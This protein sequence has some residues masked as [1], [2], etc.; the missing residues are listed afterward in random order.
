[1]YPNECLVAMWIQT[2]ISP[3]LVA[4]IMI[5]DAVYSLTI[6][7]FFLKKLSWMWF[8][9]FRLSTD[10]SFASKVGGVL[11]EP[12]ID[13]QKKLNGSNYYWFSLNMDK[14]G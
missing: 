9:S 4:W 7:D 14:V 3:C 13:S 12:V 10:P 6:C 11:V 2:W 8:S 5:V 1:M